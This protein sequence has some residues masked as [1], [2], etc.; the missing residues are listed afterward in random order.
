MPPGAGGPHP[1]D[2]HHGGW[3][4][5][6]G[7]P[8]IPGRTDHHFQRYQTHRG[9]DREVMRD[10]VSCR[11]V[12]AGRNVILTGPTGIGK[13]WIACALGVIRM[14]FSIQALW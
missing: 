7:G 2:W 12:K 9:L 10:L 4:H 11:W 13:S 6:R 14:I 8:R 3:L 5:G 1:P